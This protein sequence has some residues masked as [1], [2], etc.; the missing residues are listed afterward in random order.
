[1]PAEI[2]TVKLKSSEKQLPAFNPDVIAGL[3]GCAKE[4]V[5]T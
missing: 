5:E 4:F 1:M 2:A 3:G